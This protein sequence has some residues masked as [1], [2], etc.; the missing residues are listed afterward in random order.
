MNRS[1]LY[2]FLFALHAAISSFAADTLTLH[3]EIKSLDF[4]SPG[5]AALLRDG[6][7]GA[8]DKG[9]YRTSSDEGRSWMDLAEIPAGPGPEIDNGLLVEDREG[10]LVLVYRDDA[11]MKLNRTPDN[12]P[13]AGARLQIWTVRSTDGGKTWGDHQRLIKGFCGAMIDGICMHGGRLV[14]PL[15]E[16]RY[17]P[18]RHATVVFSSDDGGASWTRSEDIDIGGH[19][20]EDGAFEATVAEVAKQRLLMFLR[21]T[22]DRIWRSE[23]G[24][25]GRTWTEPKPT[26]IAA[27]NSPS[28]L[29]TL[30]S[31]RIALV[32]NPVSPT[33]G[34]DWPRRIKPRYAEN[35]DSVYREELL[36]A[37]SDDD[38]TTWT[39]PVV[40]AQR[41]GAKL[42]YAYMVEWRPGEIWLALRGRWFRILEA[43]FVANEASH[44]SDIEEAYL[45][46]LTFDLCIT[47]RRF[48]FEEL[49]RAFE[50]AIRSRLK[51][52]RTRCSGGGHRRCSGISRR[53]S[54]KSSSICDASCSVDISKKCSQFR[55]RLANGSK[56][57]PI[58]CVE[59]NRIED[60][61]R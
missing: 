34:A 38:G 59:Q 32:W 1:T 13:L 22:R 20:I 41:P 27:S 3:A 23:S 35:P 60:S 31:G 49:P 37:L 12:M 48:V 39:R 58:R 61:F 53:L 29:L 54:P 11:G 21:T 56:H 51:K 36:F 28:F 25:G 10:R 44:L 7:F 47:Q 4:R 17:E 26:E 42:R 43:D 9:V 30:G 50:T 18:P 55:K 57:R 46:K 45:L 16:L 40:I 19:G 15:Q 24:D 2:V 14:I 5:R 52:Y 8:V 33:N 6:R